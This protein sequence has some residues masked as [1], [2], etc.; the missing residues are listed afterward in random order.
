M[1]G[2]KFARQATAALEA[3]WEKSED[4]TPVFHILR[5]R[6]R[7]N[8]AAV[9]YCDEVLACDVTAYA[10]ILGYKRMLIDE[11]LAVR[12]VDDEYVIAGRPT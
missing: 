8:P 5:D 11:T 4:M 7:G 9:R 10:A 6:H 2:D 3:A 1:Q 12:L